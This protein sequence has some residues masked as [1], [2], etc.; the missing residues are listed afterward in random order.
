MSKY[1]LPGDVIPVNYNLDMKVFFDPMVEDEANISE[2][3]FEGRAV[4][5]IR[6]LQATSRIVFHCDQSLHILENSVQLT[7]KANGQITTIRS[8]QHYYDENQFYKIDLDAPL[9]LGEY[10]LKL[11]Y[12]GD[13]G[14]GTNLAGFYKTTYNEDGST[15]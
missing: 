9:A 4:I 10:D 7:N 15:M 14:L 6:V 12:H 2:E 5:T 1:R 13:F 3:R 11:D 8:N